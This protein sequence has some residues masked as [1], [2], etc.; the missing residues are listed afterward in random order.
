MPRRLSGTTKGPP[1]AVDFRLSDFPLGSR[2]NQPPYVQLADQLLSPSL[3]CF[4]TNSTHSIIDLPLLTMSD[5]KVTTSLE[6][7]PTHGAAFLASLQPTTAS[8]GAKTSAIMRKIDLR[9]LPVCT[10]LYF[11]S[12]LDRAAIGNAKVAGVSSCKARA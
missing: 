6:A 8:D 3:L 9:I 12:F 2:R 10:L 4:L 7:Q 1:A 11:F 5:E